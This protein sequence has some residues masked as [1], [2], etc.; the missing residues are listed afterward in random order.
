MPIHPWFSSTTERTVTSHNGST[1][2][3]RAGTL[4]AFLDAYAAGYRWFQV[5]AL[6]IKDDLL[7]MHALLGTRSRYRGRTR[8]FM[9]EIKPDVPTLHE[10]I[11]DKRL[12]DARWNI[13]LKS[14]RGLRALRCL[15][16]RLDAR[17]YDLHRILLSSPMRPSVLKTIAERFPAV[18]LAAPV[19]HGGVFG[20]SF[21]GQ[22][23]ARSADRRPYEC[24]QIQQFFVR[25]TRTTGPIRQAWTV[26]RQGTLDRLGRTEAHLI[27]DGDRL[28]LRRGAYFVD[29]RTWPCVRALALGG[30][31]WR[32]GFG[33]IG[34]VMYFVARKKWG[35]IRQVVG[36]SGGSFAVAALAQEQPP[37]QCEPPPERALAALL[38]TLETAGRTVSSYATWGALLLLAAIGVVVVAM[39]DLWQHH[40]T[41]GVLILVVI[42][43]CSSFLA[44]LFVSLRWRGLVK[45]VV[46]AARMR[47]GDQPDGDEPPRRFAIGATSLG[48]GRLYSFTSD[49]AS[50]IDEP[51][52]RPAIPLRHRHVADAVVRATSLPG[53]GQL[54]MGR[55]WLCEHVTGPHEDTC[56]WVPDRLVD[57]GTSGIF[58]RGLLIESAEPEPS[59]VVAVDAGRSLVVNRGRSLKDHVAGVG[60]RASV[61]ALLAR[62]LQTTLDVAYQTELRHLSR[63]PATV[64]DGYG[65]ALVRLAEDDTMGVASEQPSTERATPVSA[66]RRDDLDRLFFLRDRVHKFS[67]VKAGRS[68]SNRA[69]AVAVAAC[70]LKLESEPDVVGLLKEVGSLLDRGPELANVWLNVLVMG[71]PC[72]LRPEEMWCGESAHEPLRLGRMAGQ[73]LGILEHGRQT[74]ET[75]VHWP[76]GTQSVPRHRSGVR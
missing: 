26:R 28:N 67:L 33:G 52:D 73:R 44:R 39:V 72:Q 70:A 49:C 27:V 56:E 71:E 58:G 68:R 30:G 65:F 55:F 57:G 7:S 17:G 1:R 50:P 9:R 21:V 2:R 22:C 76:V 40:R 18:A 41:W 15:L 25:G 61:I 66:Q 16:E 19:L 10:L 69:V 75:C 60:Q 35:D 74:C 29:P 5:E 14:K 45:R 20:V 24:Q 46:G 54:G 59:L 42:A 31:G 37:D 32:G 64:I 36:I 8:A 38:K 48:D 53:L 6:P 63:D 43:L 11:T 4:T 12:A 62:W 34:A 47:R 23:R 3:A 51:R 13:E